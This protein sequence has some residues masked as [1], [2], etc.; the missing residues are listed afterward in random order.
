MVLTTPGGPAVERN[1]AIVSQRYL[2]LSLRL[3]YH[4]NTI[5]CYLGE[6]AEDSYLHFR[7]VGGVTD[8]NRR[9]RRAVLL[10]EILRHHDFAVDRNADLVLGRLTGASREAVG[11]KL[12]ML[13]RLV[14]FTRQLDVELRDDETMGRFVEAFLGQRP[15]P[16]CEQPEAEVRMSDV[17]QVLVLDDEPTVGERLKE[18]LEKQGMQV[19]TFVD[20][21]SA[22]AR[23]AQRQFDVVVTDLK[24]N[25]PTGLDVLVDVRSRGQA[26]Q[27]IVITGY[28]NF[29]DA[30]GAEAVGAFA[31]IPHGHAG[32]FLLPGIKHGLSDLSAG[33]TPFRGR[34]PPPC[35][36]HRSGRNSPRQHAVHC[37]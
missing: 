34:R 28:A 11:G 23:L 15:D 29:E 5:D 35:R 10:S 24:M 2:N 21:P 1:L 17:I 20:S 33:W 32:H 13:G 30:R 6:G 37:T 22:L 19:E 26:T 12:E 7:F 3:G 4:F 25:G 9:S 8:A 27:V 36:R 16:T 18:H 14:G 31:F